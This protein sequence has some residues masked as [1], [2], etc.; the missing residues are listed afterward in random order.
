M[1]SQL[2]QFKPQNQKVTKALKQDKIKIRDNDMV[3][4]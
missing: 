1:W 4:K 3:T 2:W